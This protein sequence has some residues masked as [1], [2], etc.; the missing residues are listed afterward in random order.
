MNNRINFHQVP[1]FQNTDILSV[2][3]YPTHAPWRALPS[4]ALAVDGTQTSPYRLS[5]NGTYAFRLYDKPALVDD[6]FLPDYD[7]SAFGEITV[8]GC[9]E[10]QGYGEP[11]YTNHVYPWSYEQ[12]AACAIR[13]GKGHD[14]QPNPPHIPAANP[15]GCYRKTFTVPAGFDGRDTFLCFEGVET[16]FYLWV[17]GKPV[18]YSQDSKL[19]CTFKI[20]DCIQPGENLLALQV[21]RFADSI[22][23]ED[24]DYWHL[25]G[26]HRNVWLVS[27]PVMRIEDYKITATPDLHSGAG[28]VSTDIIVS[29]EPMFA[30][31]TVRLAIY[32]GAEKLAETDGSISAA[33]QYR[34]DTTP[35]AN[36][37]RAVISL[38]KVDVWSPE[39][40]RLYTAVVMLV[41]PEG[42]VVDTESCRIGFKLLESIDNV[43]HLNGK[44]LIIRGTNRHEHCWDGGRTVSVEHMREEIR[45]M[46][47]M[48]INSVRT[49]HY[50]DSPAW[51]DLCDELGILLVCECNLETHG[52]MGGLSHNPA[53]AMSYVERAMRMVVTHKNH[54]SIYSWSLGN[55]SGCGPNH[56]AMFGFIKEY[57]P[58]RICQYEAGE[59]G[60]NMSDIRG[61]MYATVEHILQMLADPIDRRPVI[62]VEYLYQIRNSGGGMA[63][64]NDLLERY[65]LFQGGYTWDWQDK[66]LVAQTTNGTPYFAHGG[67]FGESVV[68]WVCPPFMTN[69][70]LVLA[71]LTWKPVAHEVKQAYAPVWFERQ[72][73]FSGWETVAA[74]ERFV[75]KNRCATE[76][77]AN[78]RCI[79]LLR[80]NGI[81]IKEEEIALPDLAPMTEQALDIRIPH[82]K[83]AGALYHVTFSIRRKATWY[84][85]A[86]EEVGFRQFA[87]SSG[88][89]CGIAANTA[90]VPASI[91]EDADSFT[92]TC[93]EFA[94]TL[95]KITGEI[96]RLSR[97]GADY[98][99]GGTPCFDR[100][101][102]GLDAVPDWGWRTHFDELNGLTKTIGAA[103]CFTSET[104]ARIEFPFSLHGEKPWGIAGRIAY[105]VNGAGVH[106]DYAVNVDASFTA[107]RRVGLAFVVPAGYEA[108]SYFGYGDVE[109]YKDRLYAAQIGVHESTVSAQHF[110]FAPP[111][112]C[113]G[114]EQ[115][116]WLTLANADGRTLRIESAQPFHFDAHHSRIEDY[117]QAMHDHEIP[118]RAETFLHID[119]VHAAI[120]SHMSWSTAMPPEERIQGGFF[121]LTFNI[122]AE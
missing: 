7:A 119:A 10:V 103:T 23:L 91:H 88:A 33:A 35:S 118:R 76:P 66:A 106:V 85:A 19:P 94:V 68:D 120:G 16:A 67:D 87:L 61:N 55:E 6:F 79:A 69:N 102:T 111:S 115:T 62:L 17:N 47:R 80:E 42:V 86:D 48:N 70:G 24:Q 12:D 108:L 50:P 37:G 90:N 32:D 13:T 28:T 20:T 54:P 25:S 117:Q 46:K 98:L 101:Y 30:D 83:K 74:E 14:A 121:G 36:T 77:L 75:L 109:N 63:Q 104:A 44:R 18:G 27:K 51:Y 11:I 122:T 49:C 31:H 34:N 59:P 2:N 116:H 15:T 57:D 72:R 105:T 82:E 52:L 64:F 92:V 89:A 4:E 53:Y 65:P 73:N 113:G 38:P 110:P 41:S 93:G 5:L 40:P 45:Q 22:Y 39:S 56:A 78:F 96:S 26:I 21:M 1:D 58:T 81:V 97:N 95:S 112:E 29:R 99:A 9:W 107:L 8:P 3:R 71:D 114:H 100:P 84:A 43:L 60:K